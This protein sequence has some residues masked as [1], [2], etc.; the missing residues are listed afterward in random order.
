MPCE[1]GTQ[2]ASRLIDTLPHREL[3]ALIARINGWA[4]QYG[5]AL[6]PRGADTYGDG[7]REAKRQ[8]KALVT[9]PFRSKP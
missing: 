4:D 6:I 3:V 7:M 9:S 2:F 8:I 1:G 5:E